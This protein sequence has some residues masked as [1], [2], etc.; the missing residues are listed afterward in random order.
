[1]FKKA[2]KRAESRPDRINRISKKLDARYEWHQELAEERHEKRRP[3]LLRKERKR[4]LKRHLIAYDLETTRIEAG[5]PTPL[6]ITAFSDELGYKIS[7][8]IKSLDHLREILINRF[9]DDD[10]SRARFVGWNANRFDVYF[11]CAALLSSDD[12]ILRPYLTKSKAVRGVKV[13]LKSNEKIYWEFLDGM[14]MTGIQKPLKGFLATF[15]PEYQ[16]L[17]APNWESENFD[18][19]NPEHVAYAERDSEGLYY[20]LQNAEKITREHFNIGLQ[21]TIGNM[22]IKIFQTFIPEKIMIAPLPFDIA[23]IIRL[24]V[25]RG[26]YCHC[27]RKFD[28]P[29]WKYDINQAYASAMRESFLPAGKIL[30]CNGFHKYAR[31]AVYHVRA[32]K[33]GNTIPFYLRDMAGKSEFALERFEGWITSTEYEQL[34]AEKWA[35]EFIAGYFWDDYFTMKS[36]VDTL[37]NL[38][39]NAPGGPKSA[40]GEMVKAI[41]NNSYGKTVEELSSLE[42]VLSKQCPDGFAPYQ[43]ETDLFKHLW[44]KFSAPGIRA[45]HQP[46]L[47]A[48]ITARVRM[49]VRRAILCDPDAWLY[50][51][52]DC[53]IFTRSVALDFSAT[54]Y[55]AWKIEAEGEHYRIITKKVYANHG[56]TEK[57]AKGVNI[58]KLNDKDF[59]DW[60]NGVAPRQKQVQR[61]NLLSTMTGADMFFERE[62]VGQKF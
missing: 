21:P 60:F 56:A 53:V 28:G 48:F 46:H 29:I 54:R 43:D 62:K 14:S 52:T 4:A 39:V 26:G 30:A 8:P 55:G 44:F 45:Y 9:L 59:I 3:S 31:C 18:A 13:I 37:E 40:Q 10:L 57:H 32:E 6:Y 7:T 41:G 17:N 2:V 20:A 58:N 49:V 12:Y 34:R 11:I 22:G 33:R 24:Y 36:Y 38:R 19:Q 16:K 5:T 27:Q 25:M 51:D 50:A 15:A 42:I 61:S 23:D 1:M 35:L 47:G